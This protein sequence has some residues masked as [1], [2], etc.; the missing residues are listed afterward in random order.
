[1]LAAGTA[2]NSSSDSR[3]YP[4]PESLTRRIV[5]YLSIYRIVIASLLV[6]GNFVLFTDF[7]LLSLARWFAAGLL[8]A[9]LLFAAFELFM[10]RRRG[11]DAHHRVRYALLTDVLFLSGLLF[12]LGGL[13]GGIGILLVFTSALAG[14]LL[15]LRMAL[16]LTSVATLALIG[17]AFAGLAL[18]L[19]P[20]AGLLQAGLYGATAMV[21]CLLCHRLSYWARDFRIIAEKQETR[22][23]GLEE[24][25]EVIIRNMATGVLVVDASR[26]IKL[27][28]EYAWFLLGSPKVRELLLADLSPRLDRSL[29]KWQAHPSSELRP[30]VL[31]TSQA[32]ILPS[33]AGIPGEEPSGA[34]VFLNDESVI[35]RRALELSA[36]SLAKLSGSIAHEIR[37][38][39]AALTHAAQLLDESPTITLNDMRLTNI[40]L[41]QSKRM[42]GIVENILQLSRQEQ[43]R[44][45]PVDLNAFLK[46]L[47]EEFQSTQSAKSLD[48][49]LLIEADKTFVVFDK[50][51]LHQ[52]LWKLLDNTVHHA[53]V[54]R[55]PRAEL[56][57]RKDVSA[58]YCV[59]TV[60]DNGPGIP[61]SR[62]SDIFEPFYT[63]RKEGSGLGLYIARQLCEANQAELTVDS[64][65]GIGTAFHIRVGLSLRGRSEARAMA[66]AEPGPMESSA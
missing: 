2:K 54:K 12:A 43:S 35:S 13:G 19:T 56:K 39:L 49:Q 21:G 45:E 8:V 27:M 16:F 29:E 64:Q 25:N 14:M 51:Q 32:Q 1:M 6:A 20:V 46:R 9:Y 50:S 17:Q 44:P 18:S 3:P 31:E 11:V 66:R 38:P 59:I 34:L 40:I 60:A 5:G 42:N 7:R 65:P 33:F 26:R 47:A 57:M 36:N 58:G 10:T 48:F 24:L 63:T 23:A 52:C 62:I 61:K 53:S 37:N 28:N 15:P 22:I 30:V 4:L 41:D 55:P